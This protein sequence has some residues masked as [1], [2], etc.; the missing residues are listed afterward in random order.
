MDHPGLL[1]WACPV[2]ITPPD[3]NTFSV[4][5]AGSVEGHLLVGI[6][7]QLVTDANA[8]LGAPDQVSLGTP[9]WNVPA[10]PARDFIGRDQVLAELDAVVGS[11]SPLITQAIYGMGGIGKTELVLQYAF[12]HRSQYPL[13]WWIVAAGGG[14]DRSRPRRPDVGGRRPD[15]EAATRR[16]D[17]RGRMGDRIPGYASGMAA[18]ARQRRSADRRGAAARRHH[19]WPDP[20]HEPSRRRLG[21][22]RGHGHP[23]R[24]TDR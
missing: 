19:R 21:A 24:S 11:A 20:D 8:L 3:G 13:V 1:W 23:P 6:G 7:N 22:F 14:S 17:R 12:A 4:S 15:R 10:L 16:Y 5:V 18:R 9:L 2:S